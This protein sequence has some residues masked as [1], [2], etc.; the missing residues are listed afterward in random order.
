VKNQ[1]A[2]DGLPA[3][4]GAIHGLAEW[5]LPGIINR[6]QSAAGEPIEKRAGF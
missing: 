3:R 2:K 5:G 4:E 6:N 1:R